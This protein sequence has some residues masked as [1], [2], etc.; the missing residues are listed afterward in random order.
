MADMEYDKT[1]VRT[2]T[3]PQPASSEHDKAPPE[4]GQGHLRVHSDAVDTSS[5]REPITFPFSGRTAPNRFLKAPMTER[6]C[7]WNKEGEDIV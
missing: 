7:A 5:L 4:S 2:T 1:T 6:L 3:R